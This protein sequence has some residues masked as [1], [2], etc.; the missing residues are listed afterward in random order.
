ME[1]A[2]STLEGDDLT[3]GPPGKP[4]ECLNKGHFVCNNRNSNQL[5]QKKKEDI[6]GKEELVPDNPDFSRDGPDL[7]ALLTL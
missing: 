7:S 3:I 6:Y 4:Q 5:K 2:P 1:L